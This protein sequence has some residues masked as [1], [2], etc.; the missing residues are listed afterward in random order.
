MIRLLRLRIILKSKDGHNRSLLILCRGVNRVPQKDMAKPQAPIPVHV[1]S[2]ENE[3][4]CQAGSTL[5]L[6]AL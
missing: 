4:M 2:S 3:V 5:T 1:T 6:T